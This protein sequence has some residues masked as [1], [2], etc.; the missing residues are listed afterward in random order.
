VSDEKPDFSSVVE[1]N[2]EIGF[3][4]RKPFVLH[5]HDMKG[6]TKLALDII[7]GA[8]IPILILNNL[9]RPLGAP[10]AY[11]LAALV[12][13]A[14]VLVDTLFITRRFNFITSYVALS[15]ILNGLLAFWFVDGVLFAL[16]DTASLIVG[17][18]L[19]AG[20][21]IAGR[22][23]L[24]YFMAQAMTPDTP[25]RTAAL[26]QLL[27]Q[28]AVFRTLVIGTA[29]VAAESALAGAVNF[30]LNLNTV[31][32]PF[33]VEL[34]NQQVAQVNTITRLAFPVANI[35]AFLIAFG[36]V[37]RAVYACLPKE[38]ADAKGQGELWPLIEQWQAAR[39]PSPQP[40]PGGGGSRVSP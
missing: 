10:T 40:S 9:T 18:M 34:F 14:Y 7:M 12:P 19:F 16:K 32:A 39:E 11:V 15:A 35:V 22:P 23:I 26:D 37:F 2:A 25:A 17:V 4:E 6:F 27:I 1:G 21:A 29:V 20:S 36:L 30:W 5:S 38:A 28:P 24:R 33:G 31:T 8:L 13:V 3:L